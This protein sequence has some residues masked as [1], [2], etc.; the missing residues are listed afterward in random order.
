MAATSDPFRGLSLN[1]FLIRDKTSL[2]RQSV[3]AL[4]TY[5]FYGYYLWRLS[6]ETGLVRTYLTEMFKTE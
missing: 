1:N 5:D 4:F 2:A 3:L 6:E